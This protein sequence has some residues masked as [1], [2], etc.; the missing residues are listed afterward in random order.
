MKAAVCAPVP[1]TRYPIGPNPEARM[2][3]RPSTPDA[4]EKPTPPTNH[5]RVGVF[6]IASLIGLGLGAIGGFVAGV[7]ALQIGGAQY[8]SLELGLITLLLVPVM[9]FPIPGLCTGLVAAR[10]R[11]AERGLVVGAVIFGGSQLVLFG[12]SIAELWKAVAP[13]VVVAV[14][15]GALIGAGA[16]AV[17]QGS[18]TRSATSPEDQK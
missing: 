8:P 9:T 6:I 12:S 18:S 5:R 4:T 16:G 2:D 14:V 1:S 15:L 11:S 13:V 10:Q 3:T 17:S 7:I